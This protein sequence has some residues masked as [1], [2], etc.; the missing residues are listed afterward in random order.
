M[1]TDMLSFIYML[2]S[3]HLFIPFKI[4]KKKTELNKLNE[5]EYLKTSSQ[6]SSYDQWHAFLYLHAYFK[7][8]I[9]ELI[10]LE[11]WKTPSKMSS[12]AHKHVFLYLHAQTCIKTFI[13]LLHLKS[14]KKE[15]AK[16]ARWTKMLKITPSDEQ[17][18]S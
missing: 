5:L 7:T 12:Y 18:C 2:T 10:E 17:L 8:F 6:M 14:E 3:K 16:R 4:R 11:Y 15:W 13:H 1:I 9:Y